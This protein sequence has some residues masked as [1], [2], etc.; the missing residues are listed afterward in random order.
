MSARFILRNGAGKT[1]RHRG[2]AATEQ[3]PQYVRCVSNVSQD[4][5]SFYGRALDEGLGDF[6]QLRAYC[7]VQ[8]QAN[9]AKALKLLLK[10]DFPNQDTPSK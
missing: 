6:V 1:A 10:K 4:H 8:I 7:A 9:D 3:Q 2:M 5:L